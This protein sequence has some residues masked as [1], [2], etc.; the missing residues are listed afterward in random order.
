MMP[1]M[2]KGK[3][4]GWMVG[5]DM[6]IIIT[7]GVPHSNTLYTSKKLKECQEAQVVQ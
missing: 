7:L 5:H 6:K 1:T 2:H 4:K 3:Y